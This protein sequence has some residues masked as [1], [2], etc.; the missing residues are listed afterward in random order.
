MHKIDNLVLPLPYCQL[1]KILMLC[2]VGTL[3]FVLAAECGLFL[4]AVMLLI[5]MAFFGC[6]ATEP[7]HARAAPRATSQA[8]HPVRACH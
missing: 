4:P 5:S 8:M 1:L 7:P 6:D 3:P 2:W